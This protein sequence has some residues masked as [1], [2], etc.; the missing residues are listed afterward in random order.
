MTD[1]VTLRTGHIVWTRGANAFGD[2][3]LGGMVLRRDDNPDNGEQFVVILTDCAAQPR[4]GS[5]LYHRPKGGYDNLGLV[6]RLERVAVDD[7]DPTYAADDFRGHRKV[8]D[9]AIKALRAA[10]V[11]PAHVIG[12]RAHDDLLTAYRVL[13]AEAD[14]IEKGVA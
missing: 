1:L 2:G 4:Q 10:C 14:L 9:Y 13:R 7:L 5:L 6:A 11:P 3:R 8:R 12:S